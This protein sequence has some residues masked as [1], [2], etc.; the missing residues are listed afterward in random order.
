MKCIAI[1]CLAAGVTLAAQAPPRPDPLVKEGVTE[2][3]TEHVHVIPDGSVPLVPNIG[4]IVGSRATMVIDTGLGTRNGQAVLRETQKVSRNADLYL[5][6]THIHP[7]HDLGAMA[8]PS[9]VRMIR[10]HDQEVEIADTGLEVAQRFSGM[11]ATNA[12]LLKGAEYRKASITFDKEQVVDLGG[13]RVRVMAMGTNHTRGDTGFFV[14]PDG[15]LFSGDIVMTGLPAFSSPASSVSHWLESLDRFAKLQ[16]RRI[17]PSHGPM[18]DAALIANYRTFLTTVSSRAAALKKEGR[19]LDETV[20]LL[21]TELQD[22]YD[23]QRMTSA[24]RAAYN[25]AP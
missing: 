4:I 8:F 7:E 1:L 13:V 2:K 23:R 24:I 25:A 14:E 9:S 10:S 3:I 21:Q 19:S 17:V 11:S 20:T 15:V 5:A 22:R 12:E 16:P 18:G 6:T